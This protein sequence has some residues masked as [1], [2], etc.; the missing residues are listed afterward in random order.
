MLAVRVR[1]VTGEEA[2]DL[3]RLASARGAVIALAR[4]NPRGLGYPVELWP[5]ARGQRAIHERMRRQVAQGTIWKW[6]QAE[7]LAWKRQ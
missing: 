2:Q 6:L 7:G 5:L 3:K 4:T 1:P